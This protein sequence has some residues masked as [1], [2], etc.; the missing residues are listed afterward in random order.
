[1]LYYEYTNKE[2]PMGGNIFKDTATSINIRDVAPTIMA[3]KEFLGQVFPL[4]AHS[5]RFFV[6]VGSVGKKPVSGDLDLAIDTS[7]IIRSFTST[8]LELWGIEWDEWND[9]YTLFHKRSRTATYHM[10]KMRALLT[11][12]SRKLKES[13]IPTSDNVTHGNIFTCFPQY[14]PGGVPN[15]NKVQI[16]WM[17]GD[18]EWLEWSYHSSSEKGL[19]GLHRT[20]LIVAAL[21]EAGYTFNHYCGIKEKGTEEWTVTSPEEAVSLLSQQYRKL[22]IEETYKFEDFNKWLKNSTTDTTYNAI[23]KRY[24]RILKLAKASIPDAIENIEEYP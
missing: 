3:Y 4:K 10:S 22:T 21:T 17:V 15:G 11:L 12:I 6:P 19:K 16:D 18:I 8:E 24:R 1:M 20:Q 9:L 14:G 23:I 2:A 7:H 5:L 13:G